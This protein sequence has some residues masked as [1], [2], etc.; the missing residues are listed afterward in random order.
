M[1]REN[2]L[3]E[4]DLV[5]L[6]VVISVDACVVR[7]PASL[8]IDVEPEYQPYLKLSS[9]RGKRCVGQRCFQGQPSGRIEHGA[10]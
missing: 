9:Q 10:L 1:A 4:T 3:S 6:L 8:Q 2:G 7:V 5:K